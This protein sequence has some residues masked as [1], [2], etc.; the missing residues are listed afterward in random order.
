VKSD[1]QQR[2]I[3]DYMISNYEWNKRSGDL[4]EYVKW[5][6]LIVWQ[7]ANGIIGRYS[8]KFEIDTK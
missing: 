4:F 5:W 6:N 2:R 8:W 1:H 3:L 7:K